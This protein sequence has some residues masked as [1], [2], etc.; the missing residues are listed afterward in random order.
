[1]SVPDSII[2]KVCE[3]LDI[4]DF[5]W[6]AS[7]IGTYIDEVK[8]APRGEAVAW[9][10]KRESV[11][12]KYLWMDITANSEVGAKWDVLYNGRVQPLYAH[13]PVAAVVSGAMVN[14]GAKALAK[15]HAE[16]CNV[17]ERDVWKIYGDGFR[18]EARIVITAALTAARGG[19]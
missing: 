17:D 12:D 11:D 1:M 8:E 16:D 15:R 10:L 7:I 5:D 18:D 2:T 14:A 3:R 6:V 19:A 4:Q 9:I 13:P